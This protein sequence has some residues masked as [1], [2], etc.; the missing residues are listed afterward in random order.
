MNKINNIFITGKPRVGK[1]TLIKKITESL[2]RKTFGFYTQ[3]IREKGKRTGFEIISFNSKKG[4]LASINF[5][6]NL[7]VGKYKVI[8]EDLEEIGVKSILKGLKRKDSLIVIDEIGKMELFSEEF[9]K[10]VKKALDAENKVLGTIKLDYSEFKL[11][12]RTDAII[13]TLN[14]NNKKKIKDKIEDFL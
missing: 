9:K 3:E 14:K 2:D 8:L 13:L 4:K 12:E 5:K 10:T 7:K 1:T 11:E 6:S